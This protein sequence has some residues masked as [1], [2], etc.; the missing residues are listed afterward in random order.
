MEV[1]NMNIW[2]YIIVGIFIIYAL[3]KIALLNETY[4]EIKKLYEKIIDINEEIDKI[5]KM[6]E[7]LQ[8]AVHDFKI[9]LSM[10][11]DNFES[12]LFNISNNFKETI[13][14]TQNNFSEDAENVERAFLRET[15]TIAKEFKDNSAELNREILKNL[16]TIKIEYQKIKEQCSVITE[17]I[18]NETTQTVL[19]QPPETKETNENNNTEEVKDEN[20]KI[21][22]KLMETIDNLTKRKST[23]DAGIAFENIVCKIIESN[24]FTNI[25]TTPV[26]NDDGVD[27]IAEKDGVSYA[28]QCKC[29]Q[30]TVGKK[31]VQEVYT[32]KS[33]Y[34]KDKAIVI[35]NNYFS[36]QAIETAGKLDVNL[37]D[38]NTLNEMIANVEIH[39]V[40]DLIAK[41]TGI[42]IRLPEEKK[43]LI[44]K[45]VDKKLPYFEELP[46]E[47]KS[48]LHKARFWIGEQHYSYESTLETLQTFDK[49][50]YEAAKFAVDNID[51]YYNDIK[52]D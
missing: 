47:Y 24:G 52:N 31:A 13:S 9:N 41:Y 17:N 19:F 15:A 14:E 48:A 44:S 2:F 11:S 8:S 25:D 29:Y 42:R 22:D 28:I 26:S 39:D 4:K 38:K 45:I 51:K 33:V 37:W 1:N 46:L 23:K 20:I 50:K 18:T 21:S 7:M 27:I 34:K 10:L 36:E 49:F 35:T 30:N 12:R 43:V 3:S 5:N 32:G 6:N 16:D 40:I